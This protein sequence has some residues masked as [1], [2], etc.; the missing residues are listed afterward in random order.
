MAG[1]GGNND[2]PVVCEEKLDSGGVPAAFCPWED[3]DD[4]QHETTRRLVVTASSVVV[5]GDG[6][7]KTEWRSTPATFGDDGA[8]DF[9]LE[10]IEQEAQEGAGARER[11]W[12]GS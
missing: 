4:V 8:S 12:E 9:L 10:K 5:Q 1:D 6:G 7:E 2:A 3:H 11:G